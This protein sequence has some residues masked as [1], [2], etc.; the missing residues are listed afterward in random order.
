MRQLSFK[1]AQDCATRRG[2]GMPQL[3]AHWRVHDERG[4]LLHGARGGDL[5]HHG[6]DIGPCVRPT[7][8]GPEAAPHSQNVCLDGRGSA[9][10]G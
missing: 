5:R 8:H 4:V 3:Q 7:H 6:E 9:R 10:C 1:A 2:Q